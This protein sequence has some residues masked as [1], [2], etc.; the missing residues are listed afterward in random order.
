MARSKQPARKSTDGKAPHKTH[1]SAKAARLSI[2]NR[3]EK[4]E[5]EEL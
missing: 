1:S 2:A 3:Q 4:E 5:K